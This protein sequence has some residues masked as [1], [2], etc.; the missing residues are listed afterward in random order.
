MAFTVWRPVTV[1][2]LT[3]LGAVRVLSGLRIP[4]PGEAALALTQDGLTV[5]VEGA[6]QTTGTLEATLEGLAVAIEAHPR[7][8]LLA[9]TLD[10]VTVAMALEP[11]SATTLAVTLDG[12]TVATFLAVS[13]DVVQAVLLDGIAVHMR[14]HVNLLRGTPAWYSA[15]LHDLTT[16]GL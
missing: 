10:P 4:S 13:S 3:G 8:D 11:E 5:L 14:L 6:V 15:A 2:T 16:E 9:L 1:P 7:Q 12:L